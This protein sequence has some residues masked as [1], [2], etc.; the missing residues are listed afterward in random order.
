MSEILTST[1]LTFPDSSNQNTAGVP[2]TG[3]TLTGALYQTYLRVFNGN[4]SPGANYNA[5]DM[6]NITTW[7]YNGTISSQISLLTTRNAYDDAIIQLAYIGYHSSISYTLYWI[8]FGGYGI[9][10]QLVGGSADLTISCDNST[11][12]GYGTLK[13]TPSTTTGCY[14]G[15]IIYGKNPVTAVN[16][17]LH[18][19]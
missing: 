11:S 4:L 7:D 14:L 16:G 12:P 13:V 8:T 3:G 6:R 2:L 15:A 10:T 9:N 18:T 5:N 19:S 17:T 1:G